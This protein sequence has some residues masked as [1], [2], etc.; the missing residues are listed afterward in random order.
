MYDAVGRKIGFQGAIERVYSRKIIMKR[1]I[2][3]D[4]WSSFA[5]KLDFEMDVS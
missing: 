5:V 3:L 4:G 2:Y 1:Y